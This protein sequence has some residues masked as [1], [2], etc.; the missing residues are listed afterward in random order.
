MSAPAM[1]PQEVERTNVSY[2]T[3]VFPPPPVLSFPTYIHCNDSMSLGHEHIQPVGGRQVWALTLG[4]PPVAPCTFYTYIIEHVDTYTCSRTAIEGEANRK[5]PLM[6]G[7]CIVY[8]TKI[9]MQAPRPSS[10][11]LSLRSFRFAP[12]ASSLSLRSF[13]FAIPLLLY[14]YSVQALIYYNIF[15]RP[16]PVFQLPTVLHIITIIL[17][18]PFPLL[19]LAQHGTRPIHVISPRFVQVSRWELSSVSLEFEVR[20]RFRQ[21]S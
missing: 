19:L 17:L 11:S 10:S 9:E 5:S 1:G 14:I 4:A 12:F 6:D 21:S 16:S 20:R 8:R 7:Y 3:A 2:I 13:R 15:L 18:F